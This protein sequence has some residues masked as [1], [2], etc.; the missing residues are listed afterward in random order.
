MSDLDLKDIELKEHD[1]YHDYMEEKCR[2]AEFESV[3]LLDEA[4]KEEPKIDID[5]RIYHI[6]GSTFYLS[7]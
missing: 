1:P 4:A 5:E 3:S 2:D 7:N 6:M